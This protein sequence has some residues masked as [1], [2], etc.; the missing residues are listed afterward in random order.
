MVAS[1]VGPGVPVEL[2]LG[3]QGDRESQVRAGLVAPPETLEALAEGEVRVV[4][5]RVDLEHLLECGARP[6]GLVRVEVRATEGFEDR[7]LRGFEAVGPLEDD[8][9]L[10][11]MAAREQ[12]LPASAAGRRRSRRP[13]P[14]RAAGRLRIR[15]GARPTAHPWPRWSHRS[16]PNADDPSVL[17]LAVGREVDRLEAGRFG[18]PGDAPALGDRACRRSP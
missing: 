11:V 10:R 17:Q 8:R 9:R 12:G 4:R 13:V 7:G 1:R 14:R 16:V 18:Q 15:D 6:L 5:R 2:G 3:A